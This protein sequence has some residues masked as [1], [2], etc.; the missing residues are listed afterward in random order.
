ML[1]CFELSAYIY[2]VFLYFSAGVG[3]SG[4]FIALDSLIQQA[5][6]EGKV[7]VYGYVSQMRKQRCNMI[8]TL[9]R[10]YHSWMLCTIQCM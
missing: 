7:D 3:R 9:V 2:P 4:T 10:Q 6:S 5:E 1:M 8:Q